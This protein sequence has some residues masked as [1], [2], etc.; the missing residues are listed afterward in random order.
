MRL[1]VSSCLLR[2][3]RFTFFK[4][5]TR[6]HNNSVLVLMFLRKVLLYL[7]EKVQGLEAF[8]FKGKAHVSFESFVESLNLA[9]S[10]FFLEMLE[11]FFSKRSSAS[12]NTLKRIIKIILSHASH[13]CGM[14]Q[15]SGIDINISTRFGNKATNWVIRFYSFLP[16]GRRWPLGNDR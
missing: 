12:V 14:T 2:R 13:L 15:M 7:F 16:P 6:I 10:R 8:E 11:D 4:C 3:L 5:H 1:S 9:L